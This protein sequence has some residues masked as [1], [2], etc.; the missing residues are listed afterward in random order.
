MH[1]CKRVKTCKYCGKEFIAKRPKQ[2]FC[3]KTCR[4]HHIGDKLRLPNKI[5]KYCGKE[6]HP[7]HSIQM[8]CDKNCRYADNKGENSPVRNHNLKTLICPVCKI[9]FRQKREKQECCSYKCKQILHSEKVTGKDN[10]SYKDGISYGDY[11]EKFNRAFKRRVKL[12][13]NDTCVVC[14]LQGFTVVHHLLENKDA[15]CHGEYEKNLFVTLCKSCHTKYHSNKRFNNTDVS[16]NMYEKM[17]NA[18]ISKNGK[19][20]YTREEYRFELSKIRSN[21]THKGHN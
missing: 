7:R 3:S 16:N 9:E 21:S 11:C 13:W 1:M 2:I 17:I 12:F 19:C 14:N 18:I 20:F 5:C 15:C 8:Y 6:F 4:S 10:P